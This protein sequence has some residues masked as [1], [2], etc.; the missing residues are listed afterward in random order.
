V[1]ASVDRILTTHTG[2]LPRTTELSSLLVAREKKKPFDQADLDRELDRALHLVIDKQID[3]GLDIINDGEVPKVGFSTYVTERMTGFGGQGM[4]KTPLD[5]QKFPDYADF[6]ARQIGVAE[7][8]AKVWDTALAQEAIHYEDSLDGI[9]TDVAAFDLA[10]K[11][12]EGEF[13]ETFVSAASP[14]VITT[15]MLL[16][17]SNQAYRNDREYVFGVAE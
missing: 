4:R 11:K 12:R 7:D 2:S 16:D 5:T 9:R 17:P 13:T 14:G 3:A 15:T 8:L 10:L 6:A 1:R